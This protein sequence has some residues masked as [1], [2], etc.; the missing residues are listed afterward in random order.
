MLVFCF[1]P[2]YLYVMLW[3]L[4]ISHLVADQFLTNKSQ[5]CTRYICRLGESSQEIYFS[6]CHRIC[7]V[8]SNSW[9]KVSYNLTIALSSI[10]NHTLLLI[11]YI[12]KRSFLSANTELYSAWLG[13]AESYMC[14]TVNSRK[15]FYFDIFC[16][17][18]LI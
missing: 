18:W 9:S 4:F 11:L 3:W 1:N 7:W 16:L 8:V 15:I 12:L 6:L 14:V 13:G 2:A 5:I 10:N 17:L